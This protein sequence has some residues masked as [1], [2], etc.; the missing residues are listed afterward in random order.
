LKGQ[1]V[2]EGPGRYD[3]EAA[4]VM[5][6]AKA[7]GV[8]VIIYRGDRGNGFSMQST[9]PRFIRTIPDILRS[10]ADQIDQDIKNMS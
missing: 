4:M 1:D 8:M 6:S 9:D 5:E 2:A 3:K 7:R 10:M